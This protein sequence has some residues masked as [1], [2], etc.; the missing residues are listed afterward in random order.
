MSDTNLD[1]DEHG[2]LRLTVTLIGG[3][4]I[5]RFAVNM[6][7]QQVEFFRAGR[8]ALVELREALTPDRFDPMAR[9]LLG[10]DRHA[11]LSRYFLR[12][13]FCVAC[14]RELADND[15]RRPLTHAQVVCASCDVADPAEAVAP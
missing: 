15:K 3:H 8:V 2:D 1:R 14:E 10:E 11:K 13:T 7:S 4:D 9:S 12:D 5:F 6:L